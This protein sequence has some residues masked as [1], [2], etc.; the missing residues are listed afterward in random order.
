M[1]E[2]RQPISGAASVPSAQE[3]I[4][5]LSETPKMRDFKHPSFVKVNIMGA[6]C[7]LALRRH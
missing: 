2:F 3:G 7:Q 4:G 5:R 6:T 1:R